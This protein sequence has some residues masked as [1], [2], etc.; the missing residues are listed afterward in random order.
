MFI[1]NKISLASKLSLI[2]IIAALSFVIT[3]AINL[4]ASNNNKKTMLT[5]EEQLFPLTSLASQNSILIKRAEELYTQAVSMGEEDLLTKASEAQEQL[6]ANLGDVIKLD[7]AYKENLQNLQKSIR[8]YESLNEKIAQA[9]ISGDADFALIGEQANEKTEIYNKITAELD[10]YQ[11][12]VT[13]RLTSLVNSSRKDSSSA[14]VFTLVLGTTLIVIMVLVAWLVTRNIVSTANDAANSLK[15]LADGEGNLNHQLPVKTHDELG[16]ISGHFNRF[17][18]VLKSSISA[19]MEV[20]SPLSL[21]SSDLETRMKQVADGV[22]QQSKEAEKVQQSMKEM[23]HSVADITRNA[24]EAAEAAGVAESEIKR[25][26]G[27][28]SQSVATSDELNKEIS[29]ASDVVNNLAHDTQNVNNILDVI[30]AIAEQTNLLA[31]NAAIE[32]ARAGE[33]GRG[34]SVVADEVRTLASRTADATKEIRTLVTKL[35]EAA[36]HS[37]V[38]M[39]MAT[40]KSS[41]NAAHAQSAGE[42]LIAV[43]KV[44]QSINSQN[45]QI[46]TAAG[47]QTSL[48]DRAS[49]NANRMYIS[50]SEMQNSITEVGGITVELSKFSQLLNNATGRF[51]L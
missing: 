47:E 18:M 34:F 6:Q 1:L 29:K 38:S 15:A 9:I 30:T 12:S 36:E 51:K 28:V 41:E 4:T 20:A 17:M 14:M 24:N 16:A 40:Q 8:S 11:K 39:S 46:A 21:T 7:I 23:Q 19:V 31:L 13:E 35:K 3:I 5:I 44:I 26:R 42:V 50:L 32:A 37:V 10:A 43:Q 2:V 27:V 22:A 45:S 25:G 49:E 33:Q 48:A